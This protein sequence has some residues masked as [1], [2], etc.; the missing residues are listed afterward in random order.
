MATRLPS[1]ELFTAAELP[2]R[3]LS[4]AEQVDHQLER[5][6]ALDA[7][8]PAIRALIELNPDAMSIA[9][10]RDTEVQNGTP[11]SPLHGL[12]VVVK[13]NIDTADSMLTTA[14]SL[15][16]VADRPAHDAAVVSR[17]RDA[18]LVILGKS[19]LSEWAFFRS[20]HGLS[21]WSGRGGLTRNPWEPARSAGGSSSGSG[22]AVS[23]GISPLAVGTETDGSIICPASYCG[24]VGFKP[25]ASLLPRAGIV[26][27]S[28]IQDAPGPMSRSVRLT[29]A[30]LDV[31]SAGTT[32][33]GSGA[34]FTSGIDDGAAGLR[35]GVVRDHFGS[36]AASDAVVESVLHKLGAAGVVLIDDVPAVKFSEPLESDIE[37]VLLYEFAD[38]LTRYLAERHQSAQP[39]LGPQSIADIVA[40]NNAHAEQE[41]TW[42]GQE[43][44]EQAAALIAESPTPLDS[45]MYRSTR[46][47][48]DQLVRV[49]GLDSITGEHQLDALVSPAFPPAP[50][51]DPILGDYGDGGD[52]TTAPAVAGYPILSVPVGFVGGL[53]VGLAVTGVPG[54]EATLLRLAR[55][56][57]VSLG[58]LEGGHLAPSM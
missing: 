18:G 33:G 40:F 45:D 1:A 25:S 41:L 3:D 51:I 10:E 6:G 13:D 12:A 23:A 11:R 43:Y 35:V 30:L 9:M 5:S 46:Q 37:R 53:P 20:P 15:A 57:E 58:L 2:L 56:V 48:L 17:L 26:P 16:M 49:E 55:T 29:A 42:F 22:A 44:L 34:R 38:G 7:T 14:G 28:A 52:C 31:M 8:D 32:G 54:S 50:L 19:N 27:I 47:R 4:A 39:P 21:G 24:V 36:H